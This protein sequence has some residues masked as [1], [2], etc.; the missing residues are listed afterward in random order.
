MALTQI[1]GIGSGK[2]KKLIADGIDTLEKLAE[3]T[4]LNGYS[5]E[6]HQAWVDEA[7]TLIG[8]SGS[9]VA[10]P[11][12][13]D[14][15]NPEPDT[16]APEPST[17]D[18]PLEA[19]GAGESPEENP[20]EETETPETPAPED[21]QA[22]A[23]RDP[24]DLS[25]TILSGAHKGKPVRWKEGNP[26][27]T[28]GRAGQYVDLGSVAVSKTSEDDGVTKFKFTWG[29][30]VGS[31]ELLSEEFSVFSEAVKKKAPIPATAHTGPG[32]IGRAQNWAAN[33]FGKSEGCSSCGG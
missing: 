15:E 18:A 14:A 5:I 24:V 19:S 1:N 29:E 27:L 17:D 11:A 2:A 28:I 20:S 6:I 7:K 4:D 30:T 31:A 16:Q 3:I 23:E 12:T 32:L 9:E 33:T 26:A 25:F 21:Q 22:V 10:Q 8:Q 13:Q